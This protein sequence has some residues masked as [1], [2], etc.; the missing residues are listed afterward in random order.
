MPALHGFLGEDELII[1]CNFE[2]TATGSHQID[3][4]NNVLVIGQQLFNQANGPGKVA[5]RNAIFDRNIIFYH[6]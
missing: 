2:C 4:I 5:S 1:D 3:I 6:K